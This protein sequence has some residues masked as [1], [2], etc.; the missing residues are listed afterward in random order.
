MLRSKNGL[1]YSMRPARSVIITETLLCSITS[2]TVGVRAACAARFLSAA[3]AAASESGDDQ[4]DPP[5]R[6]GRV[7][8]QQERTEVRGA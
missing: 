7:R 5:R 4:R 1:T 6:E 3:A 8:G 2:L